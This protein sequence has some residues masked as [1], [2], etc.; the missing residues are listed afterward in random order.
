VNSSAKP[1]SPTGEPHYEP[2]ESQAWKLADWSHRLGIPEQQVRQLAAEVG[3]VFD[4]IKQAWLE[5]TA[6]NVEANAFKEAQRVGTDT[7]SSPDREMSTAHVDE[8]ISGRILE[9]DLH[10]K[11]RR[12]DYDWLVPDTERIIDEYGKIRILVTLHDFEGWDPSALWEDLKWNAKHFKDI[13]RMA[14]VGDRSWHHWMTRA[15]LRFANAE[16]RYFETSELQQA[17]SW[18]GSN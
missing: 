3:P 18:I 6:G 10:G 13:E 2:I 5:R 1:R 9:V 14:I 11:L 7:H 17:R 4:N 12:E 16:V 8:T 15:C